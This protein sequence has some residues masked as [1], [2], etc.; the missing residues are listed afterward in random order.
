[1]RW[2]ETLFRAISPGVDLEGTPWESEWRENQRELYAKVMKI[3]LPLIGVAYIFHYFFFDRPEG[4]QPLE[5]W[6]QFRMGAAALMLLVCAYYF[7][8]LVRWSWYKLPGILAVGFVGFSQAHV[9]LNYPPAPWIYPFVFV[10][11]SVL[12]L[13]L[14][15]FKSLVFTI[16][17]TTLIV[18]V[19]VDAGVQFET[20]ISAA[21][22]C[23]IIAV[24]VRSSFAFEVNNFLLQKRNEYQQ[25]LNLQLQEEFSHRIR[26]FIP[27]V[28]STRIENHV[29]NENVSVT[30]AS[31][32]VL[33]PSAKQV[34]CLF[35][36]IRG[37]TQGSKDLE[38][39]VH[40]SVIPEVK[41][42]SAQIESNEGIPRK[43]GDLIFAYYDDD[44][45]EINVARAVLSGIQLS[46]K[47][48]AINA[49]VSTVEIKR[50]ILIS[51][52]EAVVGNLGGIDSSVE[53]TALGSPVN[54]LSR[55][56]DATKLPEL[57]NLLSP[58]DLVMSQQAADILGEVIATDLEQVDLEHLNISVRD[59]PETNHIYILRPSNEL[60]LK[61]TTFCKQQDVEA[62]MTKNA[63]G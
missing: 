29:D 57:A 52:G 32:S 61:L 18:P 23:C 24:M 48:K 21:I 20:L 62:T 12:I 53:I 4:L 50:Y 6:F 25:E 43:I 3:S 26:S 40:E 54:F 15:A 31:I 55:L 39:F 10:I 42:V 56:D 63:N 27:N 9:T 14:D 46:M 44:R 34:A 41:A 60:A 59:F 35:S 51:A 45:L 2:L 37:F 47:N 49:T 16:A 58:G 11:S 38:R 36:D 5:G 17:S 22:V 8:P 19:L 13:R 7:S 33:K 28:I 1:M 30:E